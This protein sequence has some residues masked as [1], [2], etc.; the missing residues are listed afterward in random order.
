MFDLLENAGAKVETSQ[1]LVG[2]G[3]NFTHDSKVEAGWEHHVISGTI[4]G[5]QSIGVAKIRGHR[6]THGKI[7]LAEDDATL[8]IPD[9]SPCGG[10]LGRIIAITATQPSDKWRLAYAPYANDSTFSIEGV[11]L[12]TPP[13]GLTGEITLK[14]AQS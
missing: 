1:E 6:D 14:R 8:I 12:L 9:G 2:W 3:F 4:S 10:H 13:H 11:L 5:V 7:V